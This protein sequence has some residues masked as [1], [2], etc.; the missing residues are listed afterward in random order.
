ML[1]NSKTGN[2]IWLKT[3]TVAAKSASRLLMELGY[4]LLIAV[5]SQKGSVVEVYAISW[6]LMRTL[7]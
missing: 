6:R 2:K 7:G 3:E 5:S 1:N 4:S